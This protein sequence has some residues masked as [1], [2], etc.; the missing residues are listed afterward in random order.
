MEL[1]RKTK[2]A[3]RLLLEPILQH[4]AFEIQQPNDRV[5]LAL[6]SCE[7][8]TCGAESKLDINVANEDQVRTWCV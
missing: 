7:F 8:V 4:S 3:Y 5:S 1:K 6:L 2:T